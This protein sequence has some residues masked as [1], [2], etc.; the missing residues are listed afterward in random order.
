MEPGVGLCD[1]HGSSEPRMLSDFMRFSPD[2]RMLLF[3]CQIQMKSPFHM[4][5]TEEVYIIV[6]TQSSQQGLWLTLYLH[7]VQHSMTEKKQN[8][9]FKQAFQLYALNAYMVRV[10]HVNYTT[11]ASLTCQLSGFKEVS[12]R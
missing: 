11:L 12:G 10:Y 8:N 9:K 2:T 6:N 1:P 7:C 3:H 5:Y 4:Y